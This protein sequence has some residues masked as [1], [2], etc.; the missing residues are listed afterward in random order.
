MRG[1]LVD[2]DDAVAGLR[3]DIGVMHLRARRA[4]RRGEIDAGAAARRRPPRWRQARNR[5]SSPA[6]ARQSRAGAAG[7]A[8][9]SQGCARRR[10]RRAKP[11]RRNAAMAPLPPVV[12]AWCKRALQ[13]L[14]DRADD[15]SAHQAA[16][17]ESAPPLWPDGR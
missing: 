12:A 14:F 11:A 2:D 5:R 8:R 16:D 10:R 4:E 1:V 3:D 17:R 15:Q 7:E 6:R 13:R 9:Q